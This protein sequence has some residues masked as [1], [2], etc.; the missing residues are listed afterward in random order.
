MAEIAAVRKF[1]GMSIVEKIIFAAKFVLFVC[2]FGF[3]F[4]LLLDDPAYDQ[5]AKRHLGEKF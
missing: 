1:A 2:S 3:A 5:I 4:P